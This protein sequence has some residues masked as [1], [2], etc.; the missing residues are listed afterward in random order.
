MGRG[1]AREKRSKFHH[2][3]VVIG[4]IS[5]LATIPQVIKVFATHSQHAAGQSLITWAVYTAIALL[6]VA[7]GIHLRELP[8]IIGNT[9]GVIMYGMVAVGILIHA[10]LTF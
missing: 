2:L 8:L 10:G 4:L 6:W 7:Y 9:L 1:M 5:P 3:M